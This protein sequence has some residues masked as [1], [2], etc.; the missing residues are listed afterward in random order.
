MQ[1][2]F[3]FIQKRPFLKKSRENKKNLRQTKMLMVII[4]I[5]GSLTCTK[6]EHINQ[7]SW[8]VTIYRPKF[9][10]IENHQ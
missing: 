1:R 4:T 2:K 3:N 8:A 5:Y 6:S 10:V 9:T 7:S